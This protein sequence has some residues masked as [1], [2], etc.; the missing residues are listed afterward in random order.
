MSYVINCKS[1]LI[2]TR[3][4]L[5]LCERNLNYKIKQFSKIINN[6]LYIL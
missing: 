3:Y 6:Y 1:K 5:I 2:S 4:K